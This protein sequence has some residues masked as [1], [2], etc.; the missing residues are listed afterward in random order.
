M[1]IVG[2]I[3]FDRCGKDTLADIIKYIINK[4]T[5]K[6][7]CKRSFGAYVK[8]SVSAVLNI[9]YWQ[10]DK[11][12]NENKII[13]VGDF[14]GT[15]RDF[16]I[17]YSEHMKSKYGKSV[18]IEPLFRDSENIDIIIIPDIRFVAEYE[19]LLDNY[20]DN[21]VL[22]DMVSTLESCGS[23]GKIYEIPDILGRHDFKLEKF[24]VK[25]KENKKQT[26]LRLSRIMRKILL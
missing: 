22:I 1:K 7:V 24:L 26:A 6:R 14:K 12:K 15:M 25:E 11:F 17:D 3:G 21:L 20:K 10:L 4:R 19:Y 18:W 8:H 2:I 13:E 16:I 23:N 9:P 5:D